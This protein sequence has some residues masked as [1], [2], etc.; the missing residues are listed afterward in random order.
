M[1]GLFIQKITQPS[2]GVLMLELS[3][4]SKSDVSKLTGSQVKGLI[5]KL[6]SNKNVIA[7]DADSRQIL[8]GRVFYN[9]S[10]KN[11]M[12]LHSIS[13]IWR[14]SASAT[15]LNIPKKKNLPTWLQDILITVLLKATLHLQSLVYFLEVLEVL[16]VL[17]VF[18][19]YYNNISHV[20]AHVLKNIS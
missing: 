7:S 1:V 3:Y 12:I 8:W 6:I 15:D 20:M 19:K 11:I 13:A 16:K 5:N 17:K 2:N 18:Q 10:H 9:I 14:P 4:K